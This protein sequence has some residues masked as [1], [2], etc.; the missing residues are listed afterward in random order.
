MPLFMDRHYSENPTREAIELAHQQDLKLQDKYD[1]KFLTYWFDE[2]RGTTFCLIEAPDESTIKR[3]HN[4]AHGDVPNEI[5]PVDPAT[6]ELFLGR[7]KDPVQQTQDKTPKVDSAYRVIMFTDLVDSTAMTTRLGQQEAMHLLHIHNA[8]T[9]QAIKDFNGKEIKHTGDGFMLSFLC[10]KQAIQ[11]AKEIQAKF[12]QHR[13]NNPKQ[14]MDIRIG[15]SSGEPVEE[16]DDLFGSTVQLAARICDLAEGNQVLLSESVYL[17][18]NQQKDGFSIHCEK[19]FKG[20]DNEVK[21]YR[22]G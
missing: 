11:C 10:A 4:E 17:D 21:V 6:V 19:R 22:V 7:I 2:E 9:R 14:A 16:N 1:I 8:I 13:K 15:L 20:F 5:I 18:V 3:V 12:E